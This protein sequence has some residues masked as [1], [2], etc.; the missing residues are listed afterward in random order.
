MTDSS[1]NYQD[2]LIRAVAQLLSRDL[3]GA[4]EVS[5]FLL[6]EAGRKVADEQNKHHRLMHY[7]AQRGGAVIWGMRERGMSFRQIDHATGIAPRTARRWLDLFLAEGVA[8]RAPAELD[9]RWQTR[10]VNGD[11]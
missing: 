7:D 5:P 11:D 9:A 4:P 8:E 2:H 6:T 10:E 1:I 3:S